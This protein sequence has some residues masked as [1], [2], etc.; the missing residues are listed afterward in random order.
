VSTPAVLR[1]ELLIS[2]VVLVMLLSWASGGIDVVAFLRYDVFVA[3]QTGNLIIIAI[4]VTQNEARDPVLPSVVSLGS[5]MV[6]VLVTALARRFLVARGSTDQQVRHQALMIEAGLLVLAAVLIL[7]R[8]DDQGDVR[9]GVIALLAFSQGIQAVVLVRVLG[10][11]VQTVAINGPLVST[12][13][14]AAQG[15]R[16]RALV[17]GSAPVGY[18]LGAG[19]GAVLQIWSSGMTLVLSAAVGVAGVF[20]GQRYHDL[21]V[22]VQA[23]DPPPGSTSAGG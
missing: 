21:E 12:L 15:Q 1:R 9:F 22:R 10:V 5:F 8:V 2:A 18:A 17:A 7:F 14:L 13:N 11:A 3:N 20:A 4:G 19:V 16:W 6:A 23:L